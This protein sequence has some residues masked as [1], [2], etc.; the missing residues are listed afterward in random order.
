VSAPF[1]AY[2][3][4]GLLWFAS[5]GQPVAVGGSV[6]YA[7][8]NEDVYAYD[9]TGNAGCSGSPTTCTPLW[10]APGTDAIVAD[11]TVY[12]STTTT[13]GAGEIVAYGLP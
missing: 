3:N 12:V 8:G 4:G 5:A 9:A 2:E 7:V 11:G 6:V 1:A 10:S 13:P